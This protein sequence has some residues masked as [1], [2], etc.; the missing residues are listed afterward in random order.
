MVATDLWSILKKKNFISSRC[1]NTLR[2]LLNSARESLILHLLWL[3]IYASKETIAR[4]S[5]VRIVRAVW[6]FTSYCSGSSISCNIFVY[7]HC[8]KAIFFSR[9]VQTIV[10]VPNIKWFIV[11]FKL[12]IIFRY[13]VRVQ[14]CIIVYVS[15]GSRRRK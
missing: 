2:V 1:L 13:S 6:C 12:K 11:A 5:F 8:N 9:I 7:G 14:F 4:R 3:W 10:V 15:V